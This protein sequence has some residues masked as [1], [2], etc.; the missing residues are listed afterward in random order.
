MEIDDWK[1]N[2][3]RSIV[4]RT[5]NGL[6]FCGEEFNKFCKDHGITRHRTVRFTPQQN[7]VA[8]RLNRTIMERVRYLFSDATL[9]EKW[10]VKAACYTMYTLNRYSHASLNFLTIE[11]KCHCLMSARNTTS[12]STRRISFTYNTRNVTI[13][14]MIFL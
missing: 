9:E 3:Y 11:E 2:F 14:L 4:P 8:E 10:W 6:E 1:A 13:V 7:G 12:F 5:N